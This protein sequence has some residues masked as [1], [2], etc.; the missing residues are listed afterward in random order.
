MFFEPPHDIERIRKFVQKQWRKIQQGRIPVQDYIIC[1]LNSSSEK[2]T[3]AVYVA[4]Q[5]AKTNPGA[6]PLRNEK[7]P[8]IVCK[9]HENKSYSTK[10]MDLA[11]APHVYMTD[12]T[13]RINEPYYIRRI[14]G[15][16]KKLFSICGRGEAY[17]V[18]EWTKCKMVTQSTNRSARIRLS[19]RIMEKGLLSSNPSNPSKGSHRILTKYF[20]SNM[21]R[22]CGDNIPNSMLVRNNEKLESVL[23][24]KCLAIPQQSIYKLGHQVQ[25]SSLRYN[26]MLKVCDACSD[27]PQSINCN[28]SSSNTNRSSNKRMPC[29]TTDCTIYYGR[30]DAHSKMKEA[31]FQFNAATEQLNYLKE[32]AVKKKKIEETNIDLLLPSSS[33]Q[34]Q[35][36][37]KLPNVRFKRSRPVDVD[38]DVDVQKEPSYKT[39]KI[40]IDCSPN[41][42]ELLQKM[43]A[44]KAWDNQLKAKVKDKKDAAK[45]G[46]VYAQFDLGNM[47]ANGEGVKESLSKAKEWWGIAAKQGHRHAIAILQELERKEKEN[48][49]EATLLQEKQNIEVARVQKAQMKTR[50]K[51]HYDFDDYYETDSNKKATSSKRS[52]SVEL[53]EDEEK[54]SPIQKR[55]KKKKKKKKRRK[56]ANVFIECTPSPNEDHVLQPNVLQIRL[57]ANKADARAQY[58]L[59]FM[60]ENGEF[61]VE[62]SIKEAK[63]WYAKAAKQEN[64]KGRQ[65]A[66]DAWNNLDSIEKEQARAD[67][68]LKTKLKNKKAFVEFEDL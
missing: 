22:L 59:G 60:Y 6:K 20:A 57:D 38:V 26:N 27:C 64:V 2:R 45:L 34:P 66:I 67:A 3:P 37:I 62:Q 56:P 1:G 46:N 41:E 9:A 7:V 65:K 29:V 42:E 39:Q 33:P 47:F 18:E 21:C 28:E 48:D 44:Q 16:L 35:S 61:G 11:V 32:E 68:R 14:C 43:L 10:N 23:C 4:K 30:E 12:Q 58:N 53:D 31:R 13:Y 17:N 51:N 25:K 19:T 8:Y 24:I 55:K 50:L 52:R 5:I 54:D 63:E 49:Q 15:V 40:Y 36:N